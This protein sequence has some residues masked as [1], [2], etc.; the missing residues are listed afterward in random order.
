VPISEPLFEFSV[1]NLPVERVVS[2]SDSM[3][4]VM[5]AGITEEWQNAKRPMVIVGQELY[6]NYGDCLDRLSAMG[7]VVVKEVL[8]NLFCEYSI[9]QADL[10]LAYDGSDHN[11]RPDLVITCGGHIVSKRLKKFIRSCKTVHWH[12]S[13]S[14]NMADTFMSLTRVVKVSDPSLFFDALPFSEFDKNYSSCWYKHELNIRNCLTNADLNNLSSYSAVRLLFDSI[15]G[16]GFDVH[17]ANS[18]SVRIAQLFAPSRYLYCRNRGINGIDGSLS[19]AVGFCAAK[20]YNGMSIVIIGDLSFFYDQ[21]GLWN[22]HHDGR[23][24]VLLLNNGGGQIFH[25]L[26]GLEKSEWRN[27]FVAAEHRTTAEGVASQ[28]GCEYLRASN[29]DELNSAIMLF[30]R[31]EAEKSIILEVV[32]DSANDDRAQKIIYETLKK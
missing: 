22:S 31:E 17:L 13:A 28:T 2:V 9:G 19:S 21:N 5:P 16:D 32:I 27:R 24:R 3:S 25:T 20:G 4:F 15:S 11:L 18:S 8:S 1:P 7:C 30:V 12:L 14:G 23:L 10:I 6:G 29:M 26:P